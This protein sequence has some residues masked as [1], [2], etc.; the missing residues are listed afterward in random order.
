MNNSS[1]ASADSA[2]HVRIVAVSLIAGILVIG[3][4]IAARPNFSDG[5]ANPN[6]IEASGPVIKAGKP[7]AFT[8]R[9]GL[10]IR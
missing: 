4:G 2:T 8:A 10:T 1:L 6:R 5:T 3:I 7:T 9:D